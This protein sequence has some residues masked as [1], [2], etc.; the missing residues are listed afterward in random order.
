MPEPSIN[1]NGHLASINRY[2]DACP[3]CRYSIDPKYKQAYWHSKNQCLDAVYVCPRVDCS[4]TFV[5]LYRFTQ[6]SKGWSYPLNLESVAPTIPVK[7]KISPDI[8]SVSGQFA[9]IFLQAS[10][11]EAYGLDAIAGVGYRKSLEFLM[12]DYCVSLLPD[13]EEQI[14]TRPLGQ[15]IDQFVENMNIK[16]CAKRATWLGND[17]THYVRSWANKDIQDLKLLIKLTVNWIEQ[18]IITERLIKDMEKPA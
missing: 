7:P 12:K 11:A 2:P 13:K 8:V 17:E 3:Y 16:Q 9:D 4:R 1:V 18:A 6:T 5:A 15:V 14:K 10:E